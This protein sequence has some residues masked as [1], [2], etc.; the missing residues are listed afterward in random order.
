V[1]DQPTRRDIVV[2]VMQL[3]M[4]AYS[5]GAPRDIWL[6]TDYTNPAQTQFLADLIGA[7]LPGMTYGY[8]AC[9]YGCSDHASWHNGGY[10]TSFPFESNE[11]LYNRSIHTANDT[12]ATFGNQAEHA[13]K[14]AKLGLAYLVELASDD[15]T[16]A[17]AQAAKAAAART[18]TR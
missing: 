2:G 10:V 17:A 9:G 3:D 14:F 6:Y 15:R 4:V 5:G 16:A 1:V 13:L 18:A 11:A 8:D 12:T 7:Y